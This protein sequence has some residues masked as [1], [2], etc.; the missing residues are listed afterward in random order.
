MSIKKKAGPPKKAKFGD[1]NSIREKVKRE[2]DKFDTMLANNL[3]E[4]LEA[5]YN[6]GMDGKSGETTRR[7]VIKELIDRSES[8]LEEVGTKP[9]QEVEVE[10]EEDVVEISLISTGM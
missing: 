6:L 1:A 8:K 9:E 7:T 2:F 4:L 5:Y 10:E 3:P